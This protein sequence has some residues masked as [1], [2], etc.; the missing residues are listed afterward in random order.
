MSDVRRGI[1]F[2]EPTVMLVSRGGTRRERVLAVGREA[3]DLLG[4]APPGSPR[5]GR[6]RTEWSRTWRRPASTCAQCCTKR[7]CACGTSPSVP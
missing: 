4:R 7:V 6:C 5:S 3:A 2:D 1:V